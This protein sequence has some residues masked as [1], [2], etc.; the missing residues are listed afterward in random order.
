VDDTHQSP[1]PLYS[2]KSSPG[3]L[4]N[5]AVAGPLWYM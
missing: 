5:H 1:S 2:F 4:D 3:A